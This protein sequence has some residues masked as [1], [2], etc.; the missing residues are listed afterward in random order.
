MNEKLTYWGSVA[1]AGVAFVL[2]LINITTIRS[3]QALQEDVA[4]RQALINNAGTLGNLDRALIEALGEAAVK[5]NDTP[6]RELLAAQGITIKDKA[7]DEKSS[8]KKTE[9]PKEE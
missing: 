9:T 3:N 6:A 4:Q 8:K 7:D 1:L 2:L 5:F